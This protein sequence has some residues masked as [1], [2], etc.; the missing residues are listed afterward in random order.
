MI[1]NCQPNKTEVLC[2]STAENDKSLI[3]EKY[4]LCGKE[5][6]RVKSTKALG[7]II[8]ENINFLEH[9]KMI[10][11]SLMKKWVM[12]CKYSNRHWGFNQKIMIQIIKTIFHSTLFYAGHIWINKSTMVEIEKLYYKILKSTI[13]AVFNIRQSLA[14]VII[15]I[16]PINIVNTVNRTKHYLKVILCNSPVDRL[17]E[18]I[19]EEVTSED[20]GR[21]DT[22]H[23]LRQV[24][25]FLKWKKTNYPES[26]T[27]TDE[28]RIYSRDITE[29]LSLSRRT[30]KYT[31]AMMTRYTEHLWKISLQNEFLL[32]GHSILPDPTMTPLPISRGTPRDVEVL[33]MSVLYENNLLNNF[34]HRFNSEQ[35]PSPL[36]DCGVEEQTAHHIL[37]RCPLV[38]SELRV[39]AFNSLKQAVGS[40]LAELDTPTT[41]LNASRHKNF[42]QQVVQ[43]VNSIKDSLRTQIEL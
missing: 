2:T 30:C 26:V 41:L 8:D 32:E 1:I 37:F 9:S 13:G 21:C 29:Y 18:F 39:R 5:I 33:A 20:A 10:Y 17:R 27:D 25:S 7:L 34:L 28:R 24:M 35:Y 16:P 42:M 43:I 31:K 19:A 12:I 6:K 23:A 22:Q 3:P 36:C 38:N 4:T 14:E 15:G 40:E 11:N